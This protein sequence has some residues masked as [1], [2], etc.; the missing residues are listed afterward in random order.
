MQEINRK[1]LKYTPILLLG[2]VFYYSP[3]IPFGM[4]FDELPYSYPMSKDSPA[5]ARL[6][7]PSATRGSNKSKHY[8]F[9]PLTVPIF[10][11]KTVIG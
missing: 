4:D 2:V 8:H 11:I 1:L 9:V 5:A 7:S 10:F 6:D 3:W